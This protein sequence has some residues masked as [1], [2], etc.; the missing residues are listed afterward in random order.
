MG[1][2]K[3]IQHCPDCNFTSRGPYAINAMRLHRMRKVKFGLHPYRSIIDS[4]I[5][6]PGIGPRGPEQSFTTQASS[7]SSEYT[8][9]ELAQSLGLKS[10]SDLVWHGR[11]GHIPK[12]HRR[13]WKRYYTASEAQTIRDFYATKSPR[14]RSKFSYRLA[15]S[16]TAKARWSHQKTKPS[17]V[18]LAGYG[19][20]SVE[21]SPNVHS[22]SQSL[23]QP[24]PSAPD[25]ASIEAREEARLKAE[26]DRL[27][28]EEIRLQNHTSYLY[29]YLSR[30]I[31]D[32]A[33]SSGLSES[34]LTQALAGL[35][36]G[37]K[38]R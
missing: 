13:G 24:D 32:Y 18:D 34:S 12:G 21:R 10:K 17:I 14:I 35:L 31:E 23:N 5:S 26:V 30:S 28:A 38:V 6:K 3:T 2:P 16:K 27:R 22:P 4:H 11:K 15:A 37:R 29:G 9:T 1:R 20:S 36:Q 7:E 8:Q 19:L 25:P 33:R